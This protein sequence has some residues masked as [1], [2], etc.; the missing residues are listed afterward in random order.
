M[1]CKICGK[2]D[3]DDNTLWAI[4][5]VG[6]ICDECLDKLARIDEEARKLRKESK[7]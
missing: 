5:E 6:I 1:H 4:P 2:E 3:R 7:K